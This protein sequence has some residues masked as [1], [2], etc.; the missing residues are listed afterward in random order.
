[1]LRKLRELPF[2]ADNIKLWVEGREKEADILEVVSKH[3]KPCQTCDAICRVTLVLR[4]YCEEPC[5]YSQS[6]DAAARK[7]REGGHILNLDTTMSEDACS[8]LGCKFNHRYKTMVMEFDHCYQNHKKD[9]DIYFELSEQ[10]MEKPDNT[11]TVYFEI[12][13]IASQYT[14]FTAQNLLPDGV[15]LLKV[16]Y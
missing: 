12:H 8:A 14:R 5:V 4:V 3:F 6:L 1:M 2:A 15:S 10:S 13:D 7:Y 11:E 9:K 16:R